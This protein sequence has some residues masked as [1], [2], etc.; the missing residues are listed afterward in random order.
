MAGQA[1]AGG[2][3]SCQDIPSISVGCR[4]LSY[5]QHNTDHIHRNLAYGRLVKFEGANPDF[6]RCESHTSVVAGTSL[7]TTPAEMWAVGR[8]RK[9]SSSHIRVF[10]CVPTHRGRSAC[11]GSG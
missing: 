7:A 1:G 3:A 6:A 5:D 10:R 8:T 11:Y 2:G 9:S 4:R